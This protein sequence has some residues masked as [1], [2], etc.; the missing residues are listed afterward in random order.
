MATGDVFRRLVS[1][2]LARAFANVFDQ[3]TQPCHFV[4]STRA[5]IDNLAAMLRATTELDPEATIVPL[6]GRSAYDSA[7]RA[8]IM[9]K[10]Q[11]V[12]P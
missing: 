10:P 3:A 11:G 5:R 12:A 2:V 8:T 4:L 9:S 6:D 1:R 7:S